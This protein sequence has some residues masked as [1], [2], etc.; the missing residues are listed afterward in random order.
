LTIYHIMIIIYHMAKYVI[1]LFSVLV[2]S[3]HSL[4]E[5]GLENDINYESTIYNFVMKGFS[6]SF[7]DG[8]IYGSDILLHFGEIINIT[9][10]RNSFNQ[11]FLEIEFDEIYVRIYKKEYIELF[12][13]QNITNEIFSGFLITAIVAKENV[14]YLYDVKIGMTI[15]DF[16]KIFGQIGDGNRYYYKNR[17][18]EIVW[19]ET[20]DGFIS[21]D[22]LFMMALRDKYI[23]GEIDRFATMDISEN[24]ISSI[25]WLF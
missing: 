2:F 14:S 9:V 3:C 11:E 6:H 1:I 8:R 5:K 20:M 25:S 7:N 12:K 21:N 22:T 24:K 23:R 18:M 13:N 19:A 16:V 17:I 15:D 10:D 4:A